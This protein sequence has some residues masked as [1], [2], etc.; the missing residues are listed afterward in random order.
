[1]EVNYFLFFIAL[2]II[3][4]AIENQSQK[5]MRYILLLAEYLMF[6]CE[7]IEWEEGREVFAW[8]KVSSFYYHPEWFNASKDEPFYIEFAEEYEREILNEE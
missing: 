4:F 8:I 3:V 5:I 6:F 7:W 1:M 2:S